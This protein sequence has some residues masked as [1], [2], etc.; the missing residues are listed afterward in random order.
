MNKTISARSN[1]ELPE[2]GTV[3]GDT[4][5]KRNI[6]PMDR[7]DHVYGIGSDVWAGINSKWNSGKTGSFLVS[8]NNEGDTL[9]NFTDYDCIVNFGSGTYRTPVELVSY[10]YKELLT[11]LP[12]YNDTV[13]RMIPP[14]RLLP[15]YIIDFGEFKVNYMEGLNPDLDLSGK[16][17]LNSLHETDNF[18]FIRYTN[19]QDSPNNIKKKAVKFY[20]VL[21]DKKQG[22]LFH[23][24]GFTLLSEGILND[25]DGGISFWPEF[26]TPQGEMMKLMSGKNIKDYINSEAFTKGPATSEQRKK[27]ISLANGLKDRD[28][29]IIIV[30]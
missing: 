9:C 23:Q 15:V 2:I 3:S 12:E 24:P 30:K 28:M 25:L 11:I 29:I 27:Q 21:F 16:F 17:L 20:N 10:Y 8:F 13:F 1:P 19:N 18:L 26:I 14:N 5:I 22:K 7:F 6:S 4:L